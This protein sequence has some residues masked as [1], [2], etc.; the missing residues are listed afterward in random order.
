MVKMRTA[1]PKWLMSV[2]SCRR[3]ILQRLNLG[4]LGSRSTEKRAACEPGAML[5]VDEVI[6]TEEQPSR[7]SPAARSR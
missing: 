6:A 7:S 1:V 4:T 3:E 5:I 2:A